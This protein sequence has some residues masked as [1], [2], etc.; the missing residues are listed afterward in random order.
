MA[1][2]RL[3]DAFAQHPKLEGWTSA[4]KWALIELFCYCARH[5]TEG[6]V[7]GDLSLLPRAVTRSVLE[8][9]ERS[10]ILDR[11]DH[12]LTVHDWATYNPS[13][14]TAA[15]RMKRMR[16]RNA[17]RNAESNATVTPAVT[18][19]ARLPSPTT[20]DSKNESLVRDE[21]WDALVAE[22]GEPATASERGRRNKALKELR[23]IDAT[24]DE[25]RRRC[26]AYRR[27]Y[28]TATLTPQALTGNWSSLTAPPPQAQPT[29][30]RAEPEL[31]DAQHLENVQRIREL[32]AGLTKEV[33]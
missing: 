31:S 9:A 20:R 19:R 26:R 14:V 2:L 24:A 30:V 32:F 4:R 16:E 33:A 6:H 8:L 3:D 1:W 5:K 29:E 25:V 21:L 7:P 15:E 23:A 13:D 27:L 12:G 11:D 22:L 18:S 28:P 10:G 17:S